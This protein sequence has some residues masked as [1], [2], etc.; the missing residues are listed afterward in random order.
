MTPP[1]I[2]GAINRR[3]S[4]QGQRVPRWRREFPYRWDSD[5]TVSRRELLRFA[6]AVSGTLFAATAAIA[7]LGLFQRKIVV[8]QPIV[9]AA[10]VPVGQAVYF[11]YPTAEN[12]AVLIH[13][14]S[15]EF[16]AFSQR[17][18]HLSC[19]VYFDDGQQKLL[20][21]CHDGAF[22][23]GTGEPVAGPPQRPLPRIALENVGGTLYATGETPGEVPR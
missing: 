20:C 21:P 22:D 8:R 2:S 19:A 16:V 18:T 5:D 15:G 11:N 14:R 9:P 13:L 12:Q 3:A 1:D 23:P 17:C 4:G 6:V 7:G 10:K